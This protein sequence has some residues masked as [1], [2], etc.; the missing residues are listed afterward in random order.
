MAIPD[1]L[2]PV[3]QEKFDGTGSKDKFT[4]SF[5]N[6]FEE[7]DVFVYVWNATTAVYDVKTKDTHYTQND[8]EITFTSGNIPASGTGNVLIR[9]R[10][11]IDK[12]KVDYQPGSSVRA[13]DLDDNQTQVINKLQELENGTLSN[14][15]ASLQ[16]N[17][18]LNNFNITNN[19]DA[20]VGLHMGED[21]PANPVNGS[22]WFETCSG[23]T[24]VYYTDTDSSGW[25]DT[26]PTYTQVGTSDEALPL[27]GGTMTGF[28]NLHTNPTSNMHAATKQ[29][30]DTATAS[31]LSDGDKG[32][33][34]VASS[35]ASWTIDDNAVDAAAI[36]DNAVGLDQLAGIARGKIIYGDSSGNPAVLTAGA[37]GEVLKS[38]G[39]D[40]SWGSVSGSGT[41]TAVN[42]AGGTGLTSTGS[43]YTTSGTVTVNMDNTAVTA[44]T[45]T[46]ANITVDAQGRLTAAANGTGGGVVN[47][48]QG[49]AN[50]VTRTIVS[51]L[52]DTV[53]AKDFGVVGDGST[54]DTAN[55]QEA[56]DN[57]DNKIVFLPKGAYKIT[58]SL[59]IKGN[60]RGFVGDESMPVIRLDLSSATAQT[61]AII[62]KNTNSTT[63]NEYARLEN[64]YIHRKVSN[65]F[66]A[67][68]FPTVPGEN[69]AGVS[70]N[71]DVY[72]GAGGCQRG[73]IRNVRVGNFSTGFYFNNVVGYSVQECLVQQLV[74]H[75]ASGSVT[76]NSSKYCIGYHFDGTPFSTGSMSPLAS[77]EVTQC[78]VDNSGVSGH[79]ANTDD[80]K[81]I[82]FYLKGNDLRD[83]FL[84][85]CETAQGQ[86]GIWGLT[87]T[88]DYVFDIH[89]DRPI[90]DQFSK[91]GI[92]FE[93]IGSKTGDT[94]GVGGVSINGGYA[95]GKGNSNSCITFKQCNGCTVT[96][97][98]QFLG[99]SNNTTTDRG[100]WLHDS[101]SCAIVGNRFANN[102]K[103]IVV[104]GSHWN[105]IT[106]NVISSAPHAS[107]NPSTHA[108]IHFVNSST[109]NTFIGNTVR[110]HSSSNKLAFGIAIDAGSN[111]NTFRANKID[112][113]DTVNTRVNDNGTDNNFA[114]TFDGLAINNTYLEAKSGIGT[115]TFKDD[116][117]TGMWQDASD[118]LSLY[119]GGD[120]MVTLDKGTGH[121]FLRCNGNNAQGNNNEAIHMNVGGGVAMK[122]GNA[123]TIISFYGSGSTRQGYIGVYTS[124]LSSTNLYENNTTRNVLL[125]GSASD[126]RLKENIAPLTGGIERLKN[127]KPSRFS[128]KDSPGFEQDGF[129]AH[130]VQEIVPEAVGG[131]KDALT[132]DGEIEPQVV[133]PAKLVPL[134]TAA[135]Q[136]LT[137]RVEALEG[138]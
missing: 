77:I 48:N 85:K 52:Q 83:I 117:N 56:L 15:G 14:T 112:A 38:D 1:P 59:I 68:P 104:Q 102:Y 69:D 138:N 20:I 98:F 87:T 57:S 42:V 40:I 90:I 101:T 115:Y 118:R 78:S 10:T 107:N 89:I 7:D 58:S 31:G 63:L 99:L 2:V 67:P 123:S 103:S 111:N 71:G 9:R 119:A 23:R 26:T 33:I 108:G 35:G 3:T 64:L 4:F 36:A 106:S 22:R 43:G 127:L 91:T 12:A 51:R 74:N 122:G 61:P 65:A 30:V 29:Y 81:S 16:G 66:S 41:V 28:I 113:L 95:V 27:A 50:A 125:F 54:D 75:A 97:G 96:G 44:G 121:L 8:Q 5:S 60:Y 76:G 120:R 133:D 124:G 94:P 49:D 45:Y 105:T 100:I 137:A 17:L 86:Y 126:Y 109:K 24:Y 70:V 114:D 129:I 136:E 62:I 82:G 88:N 93:Q 116:N 134:L 32:D 46:N 39:T 132:K 53:S 13:D 25:V 6:P 72:N 18:E 21:P 131:T 37:N 55:L 84:N 79:G 128:W 92:F 80:T 19:G 135:L 47:Y 110:G 130:E 34:T 73:R 11:D